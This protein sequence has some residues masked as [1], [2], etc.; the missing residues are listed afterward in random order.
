M[1][2]LNPGIVEIISKDHSLK[3]AIQ[4]EGSAIIVMK[5]MYQNNTCG[6]KNEAKHKILKD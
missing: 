3:L 1:K 5:K 6:S 4:L 2:M